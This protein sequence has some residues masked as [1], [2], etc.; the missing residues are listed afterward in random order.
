MSTFCETDIF[1]FL[2][3]IVVDFS[4]N[5]RKK[6]GKEQKGESRSGI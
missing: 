3:F 6:S 1:I 5:E 4:N 2:I